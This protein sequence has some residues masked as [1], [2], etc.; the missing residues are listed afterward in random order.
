MARPSLLVIAWRDSLGWRRASGPGPLRLRLISPPPTPRR[1]PRNPAL[2]D[3]GWQGAVCRRRSSAVRPARP[4]PGTSRNPEKA[5]MFQPAPSR[6]VRESAST[7]R[8]RTQRHAQCGAVTFVQRFGDALNL[9]VHFHSLVLEDQPLLALLYAASV[10]GRGHRS[11]RVDASARRSAG[12]EAHRP[13]RHAGLRHVQRADPGL[14]G[15]LPDRAEEGLFHK[16]PTEFQCDGFRDRCRRVGLARP[17]RSRPRSGRRRGS[18]ATVRR[19]G[20]WTRARR[21]TRPSRG[22]A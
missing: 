2:S 5:R 3:R 9:N 21:G 8:T 19:R 16:V 6:G 14:S 15:L 20:C 7:T 4:D 18:R 22:P 17:S 1:L 10:A 13:R 11:Q 12:S